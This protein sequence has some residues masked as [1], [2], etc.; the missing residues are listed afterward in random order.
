MS[1]TICFKHNFHSVCVC[2]SERAIFMALNAVFIRFYTYSVSSKIDDDGPMKK[3]ER[4]FF[5]FVIL[6][7]EKMLNFWPPNIFYLLTL[8]R[9]AFEHNGKAFQIDH[10]TFKIL[11]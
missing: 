5:S 3:N 6:W 8:K 9:R 11:L 4:K 1:I 10:I 7:D 2:A